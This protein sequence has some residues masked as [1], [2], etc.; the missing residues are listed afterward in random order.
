MAV[1]MD[2]K[3]YAIK[4]KAVS[5]LVSGLKLVG[6]TRWAKLTEKMSGV[7]RKFVFMAAIT[8]TKHGVVIT[9]AAIAKEASQSWTC[10]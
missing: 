2:P 4:T 1:S 3:W 10:T 6:S 8:I 5:M 9:A 7:Q